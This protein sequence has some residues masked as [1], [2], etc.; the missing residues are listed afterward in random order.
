MPSPR[1]TW[2]AVLAAIDDAA[3]YSIP[4]VAKLLG[5]SR[6]AA[7]ERFETINASV[8]GMLL[9]TIGKQVRMRGRALRAAVALFDGSDLVERVERLEERVDA[10]EERLPPDRPSGPVKCTAPAVRRR[11]A[12]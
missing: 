11:S 8:H 10:I 4:E 2:D 6:S 7:Y 1:P 9:Y 3:E 12:A 5:I